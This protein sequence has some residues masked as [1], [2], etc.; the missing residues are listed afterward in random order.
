MV[1]QVFVGLKQIPCVFDELKMQRCEID[2]FLVAF[3]VFIIMFYRGFEWFSLWFCLY[4]RR[5]P[6]LVSSYGHLVFAEV[7]LQTRPRQMKS[8]GLLGSNCQ[9]YVQ[10]PFSVSSEFSKVEDDFFQ[11]RGNHRKNTVSACKGVSYLLLSGWE[12]SQAMASKVL[13]PSIAQLD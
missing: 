10:E 4:F 8:Y 6:R 9:H 13:R 7:R 11:P 12:G 2:I 5:F 1:V 3:V